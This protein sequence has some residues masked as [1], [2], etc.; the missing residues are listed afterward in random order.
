MLPSY[1]LP[2]RALPCRALTIIREYSKPLTR[3]DWRKSKPIVTTYRLYIN[4]INNYSEICYYILSN[5]WLTDWYQLYTY[6]KTYGFDNYYYY[7][8]NH[9]ILQIDG[10][11]QLSK[12]KRHLLKDA[13]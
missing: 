6:I 4:V 12:E 13:K 10:I 5:I 3:P 1:A 7:N 2:I 8:K 9:N 11:A